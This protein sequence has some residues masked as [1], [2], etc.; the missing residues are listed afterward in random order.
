[1]DCERA[2]DAIS[3]GTR[4]RTAPEARCEIESSDGSALRLNRGT[5]ISISD[6]RRVPLTRGRHGGD[7]ARAERACRVAVPPAALDV[8][9][10]ASRFDID[11]DS[12]AATANV[13][14]L[15]GEARLVSK[16]WEESAKSLVKKDEFA[17]VE[18]NAIV[19]KDRI[20]DAVR[21]T[22]WMDELLALKGHENPEIRARIET[23]LAS[24]GRSKT[25]YLREREIRALGDSC[26]APLLSYVRSKESLESYKRRHRAMEIACEIAP[27]RFVPELLYLLQDEDGAIREHA[28]GALERLTGYRA[29]QTARW[30]SDDR[31]NLRP[32][33]E[34]WLEWY[35]RNHESYPPSTFDHSWRRSRTPPKAPH[36]KARQEAPRHGLKG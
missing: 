20:H 6:A 5:E 26:V 12:A 32:F 10:S 7:A 8:L 36:K 23:F 11:L 14:V 33:Y 29:T 27:S 34:R 22:I 19:K 16:H 35:A 21:A 31:H 15:D 25:T 30:S 18:K 1:M 2:Q 4:I 17:R 24:I 13:S 3:A 9:A 28:A